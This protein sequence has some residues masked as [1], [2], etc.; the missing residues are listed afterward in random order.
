MCNRYYFVCLDATIK[1]LT[2]ITVG[3]F[4]SNTFEVGDVEEI[5]DWC[6]STCMDDRVDRLSFTI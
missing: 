1:D 4:G 3:T 6:C 5:D 2:L